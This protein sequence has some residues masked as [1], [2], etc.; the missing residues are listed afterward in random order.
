MAAIDGQTQ[1]RPTVIALAPTMASSTHFNANADVHNLHETEGQMRQ[2]DAA[3]YELPQ[4]Q[5]RVRL[6]SASATTAEEVAE[7]RR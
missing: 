7:Q 3:M 5:A 4:G 1:S 2:G 6:S